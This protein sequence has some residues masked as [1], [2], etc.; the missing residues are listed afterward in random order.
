MDRLDALR[1]HVGRRGFEAAVLAKPP[2]IAAFFRGAE[3]SLGFRQEAPRRIALCVSPDKIVLLGNRTE[4]ARVAE[5]ELSWV[6]GL[7]QH[8]FRWDEWKLEESV[9]AFLASEGIKQV[10]SDVGG[11]GEDIGATLEEMHYPLSDGE[12]ETLRELA[13]ET[14]A[15]VES[16]GKNVQAGATEAQVAGQLAGELVPRGILPELIM[17]AADDRIARF[18]HCVPKDN[19]IRQLAL[20]SVTVHRRGLYVSLTRLVSLG[21]VSQEWRERQAAANRIDAKAILLSK[22]GAV[23]GDIF[24]SMMQSYAD[25]GHPDE[26]QAH[27]QGGP[28]GFR[29]RDYKATESES[30]CLA[31]RQPVVWN[32]TFG[33]A[34]SE[35]TI[36]TGESEQAPEVLTDTGA[37]AYYDVEVDEGTVRR[38]MILEK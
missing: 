12:I 21:P 25:E 7:V 37:W 6:P 18:R 4:V 8:P 35:D 34:K 9:K 36:L 29:G 2:N 24:R 32:P 16:A 38:P 30:R 33:G 28:A 31:E 5:D 13:R 11:L 17:V 14:A 3:I 23:V 15:V 22:P 20:L 19:P 1:A 27:H 10:C 26:W